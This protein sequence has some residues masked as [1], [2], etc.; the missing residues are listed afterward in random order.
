MLPEPLPL[1]PLPPL[2]L[3][4]VLPPL[5]PPLVEPLVEPPLVEPLPLLDVAAPEDEPLSPPEP[6]PVLLP[7]AT[8][9]SATA[10]QPTKDVS[11]LIFIATPGVTREPGPA[12][13][14]LQTATPEQPPVHSLTTWAGG[15]AVRESAAAH[16]LGLVELLL[17]GGAI[18]RLGDQLR[19]PPACAEIKRLE[20]DAEPRRAGRLALLRR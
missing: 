4:L 11:T 15:R 1:E 20:T 5:E 17:V 7:Q 18:R 6:D 19:D 16:S 2:E 9:V 14:R 8:T 13:P 10:P 3:P 12:I